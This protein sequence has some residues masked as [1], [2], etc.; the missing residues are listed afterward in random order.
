MQS[1]VISENNALL[2]NSVPEQE[3]L[4]PMLQ[5]VVF[6]DGAA[7]GVW[8]RPHSYMSIRRIRFSGRFLQSYRRRDFKI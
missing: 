4:L 7:S 8:S 6:G 2:S 1:Y 5:A 3:T